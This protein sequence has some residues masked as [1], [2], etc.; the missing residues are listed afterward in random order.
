MFSRR[1]LL[2]VF[3][4]LALSIGVYAAASSLAFAAA[5]SHL[6]DMRD[7]PVS[8]A[9]DAGDDTGDDGAV[10]PTLFR[11][12]LK[13]GTTVTSY[14]EFARVG[15]RVVFAMPLGDGRQQLASLSEGEID[16]ARTDGYAHAVRAAHYAATAGEREFSAMSARIAGALTEI[17]QATDPAE[18]LRRA[19]AARR[20]LADWPAAHFG[21]KANE[22]RENL[23]VLDEVIAGL[24]AKTSQTR[25][26]IALVSGAVAPP[27]VPLLEPP[28]LQES[29]AEA[30]RLA[31]LAGSPAERVELLRGAAVALDAADPAVRTEPWAETARAR[32]RDTIETE[33]RA[34]RA[35]ASLTSRVL[36]L[37]E[38]RSKRAD[39]RGLAKL[40]EEVV[41]RD[42]R[43]GHARP[44]EIGSL[45]ATLDRRLDAAQRLRLARDRWTVKAAGYRSYQ[46]GVAP[47]VDLLQRAQRALN[48]IRALAGP[49]TATLT[50][51]GRRFD[52]L[53]PGVRTMFVPAEL[54]GAHASLVSALQ[55]AEAAVRQRQRAIVD[56]DMARAR[57]ASAA[58]AGALMLFER[59]QTELAKALEVP[60]LP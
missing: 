16:W 1:F 45:L 49:S 35:Y 30:L 24:R 47:R 33:V 38:S 5:P 37:S 59:V 14:G 60:E 15:E 17:A 55:L 7:A 54:K 18:Q 12:F 25:F 31:T 44:E 6:S 48:D 2:F 56:N 39:V 13:D 9:E 57:N 22:I 23:G 51:L 42:A 40:R 4:H 11:I 43:L 50:D 3:A 19:Q 8:D 27:P 10:D 36:R 21:Y 20:E 41:R 46:R 58:A 29:I 34:D 28:S 53:Q 32:M 52:R 26:D